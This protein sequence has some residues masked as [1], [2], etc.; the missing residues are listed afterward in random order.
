MNYTEFLDIA[1]LTTTLCTCLEYKEYIE[2]VYTNSELDKRQWWLANSFAIVKFLLRARGKEIKELREE[3]ERLDAEN[4]MLKKVETDLR[5]NEYAT[6]Q[7]L[8][9]NLANII[10]SL[11]E[12]K[13]DE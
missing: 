9:K 6:K 4:T 8:I 5:T 11:K 13:K 7:A 3:I 10:D 12:E 2:P 1:S